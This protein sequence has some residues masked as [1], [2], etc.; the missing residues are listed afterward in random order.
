MNFHTIRWLEAHHNK[1][2][3]HQAALDPSK[4]IKLS[5]MFQHMDYDGNG[6]IELDEIQQALETICY[7]ELK[8]QEILAKFE[9]MDTDGSGELD[10]EEFVAVMT[11]DLQGQ[12]FFNLKDEQDQGVQHQAFYE[13]A[14]TYRREMLL[15]IIEGR[16]N[17]FEKN[18]FKNHVEGMENFLPAGYEEE[19]E[20]E[21]EK[22]KEKKGKEDGD[23][24]DDDVDKANQAPAFSKFKELFDLQLINDKAHEAKEI[25]RKSRIKQQEKRRWISEVQRN[26]KS[27]KTM[28]KFKSMLKEEKS[29]GRNRDFKRL[30]GTPPVVPDNTKAVAAAI[31]I[32]IDSTLAFSAT[33]TAPHSNPTPPSDP[34]PTVPTTA[35][36]FLT[37]TSSEHFTTNLL[38]TS[39]LPDS[40]L[41]PLP[42]YTDLFSPED[43]NENENESDFPLINGV[44]A[45]TLVSQALSM[46]GMES[47]NSSYNNSSSNNNNNNNN[48]RTAAIRATK[49]L[50]PSS[51]ESRRVERRTPTMQ[52]A[53]RSPS[54]M[55]TPPIDGDAEAARKARMTRLTAM[56]TR[57]RT[58]ESSEEEEGE[59]EEEDDDDANNPS[60]R[61]RSAFFKRMN[62]INESKTEQKKI[63]NQYAFGGPAPD[64]TAA[65]T[66]TATATT[67][68]APVTPRPP[69]DAALN[70]ALA[71]IHTPIDI[72][73]S[74]LK[75]KKD[76]TELTQG[77]LT[78]LKLHAYYD[79]K[80][81]RLEYNAGNG[82]SLSPAIPHPSYSPEPPPTVDHYAEQT[83]NSRAARFSRKF[84]KKTNARPTFADMSKV[85]KQ[86]DLQKQRD[87]APKSKPSP[88]FFRR[89]SS[90]MTQS[91][92]ESPRLFEPA[93]PRSN[94]ELLS[95]YV[96]SPRRFIV[97]REQL[98]QV[99]RDHD[100]QNNDKRKSLFMM[101]MDNRGRSTQVYKNLRAQEQERRSGERSGERVV[102]DNS[103]TL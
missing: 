24:S 16:G 52:R 13:F 32:D 5:E 61:K 25:E 93:S 21:K 34:T 19:E 78:L 83:T 37:T 46:M 50:S 33:L 81:A 51:G 49:F 75:K 10:F 15:E 14:T 12:D 85:G 65:T 79:A 6:T 53:T 11:S 96:A 1:K 28:R 22:E 58:P 3:M 94:F 44:A 39:M 42:D 69:A 47:P 80:S 26:N 103:K 27:A 97:Q 2:F 43:E 100:D 60:T 35:P 71:K 98:Q 45:D 90:M 54:G 88:N 9:L 68:A 70:L 41:A 63:D 36:D 7:N 20:K 59:E 4:V 87:D 76:Q 55:V 64:T 56:F 95:S 82:D 23:L 72:T 77:Q 30:F 92:R 86:L 102:V 101:P 84:V 67:N 99:G 31:N 66:T 91:P 17:F 29:K 73:P 38:L 74:K 57:A 62:Y 48:R 40:T 8:A 18:A 89:K